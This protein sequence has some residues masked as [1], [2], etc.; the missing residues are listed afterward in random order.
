MTTRVYKYGAV[1]LEQM[2]QDGIK[3]LFRANRLWNE[4]VAIHNDARDKYESARF[5]ADAEYKKLGEQLDT[6][7]E[8]ISIAFQDKRKARGAAG[9]RDADDPL[10]KAANEKITAL[11]RQRSALWKAIKP[12]RIRADKL[13]D[14]KALNDDFRRRVNA[15]QRVENTDGLNGACA[16]EVARYFKVA[17]DRAFK[18]RAKLRFHRFDGTGFW[19]YRF[20]E[21]GA[22]VDG[23]SFSTL[24]TGNKTEANDGRPF[25][26]TEKSRRG[27][28]VIYKL[29]AKLAGGAKMDSKVY[30]HFDLILH[31]PIPKDAQI[32]NAKLVRRRTG[33]KFSH[34]VSFTLRL[35]DAKPAKIGCTV[36]GVDINFRQI[37]GEEDATG[38]RPVV[39]YRVGTVATNDDSLETEAIGIMR[40][41]K[42]GFLARMTHIED[43]RS[44]MDKNATELGKKLIPLLK[45]AKPLPEDH[46]QFRFVHRLRNMRANVT[47]DFERSYKMARWFMRAPE[48]AAFFGPEIENL[49]M[50]WWNDNSLKYREMQN[51]RRKALADRREY[52]RMEAARMVKYGL[53][54]AVEELDMSKWA[55]KKDA[56]NK[57]S[58]R[59]LSNR[60]LVAP[61]ELIGALQNAVEREGL[62]FVKINP[63][64]T[65][66]TCHACGAVNKKLSGEDVEWTCPA[67]GV[68]HDRDVNAAIN[69][70]KAGFLKLMKEKRK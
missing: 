38:R 44:R 2:P 22:S 19:F 58:S 45:T 12:A 60:F 30:G 40:E 1:P 49:V 14:K 3:E 36:L 68:V 67:C 41:N 53:P 63:A 70:A 18:E 57:L 25:V 47:L 17:R 13:I 46:P 59:A 37:K 27:K 52:Y 64:Y 15:A 34:A 16:N 8:Q 35:P 24:Q 6:L 48:D 62:A 33:D 4:L 56:D 9:T 69:I 28:R 54:I 65:S 32:Q 50:N 61:S 42:R 20:R 23:V 51:L 29:R 5:A 21:T 26:L 10:V 31:R 55:E 7:E 11:K 43:L 39:G 66:K